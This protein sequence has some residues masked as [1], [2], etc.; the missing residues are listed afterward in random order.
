MSQAIVA[1]Q[2]GL[3]LVTAP[4]KEDAIAISQALIT[5]K[6]AACVSLFPVHSIYTWQGNIEQEDEW[7]LII[8]TDLT[9]FATLAARIHELHPYEV[10]E[11]VALPFQHGAETYLAW[12]GEQ[13]RPAT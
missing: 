1:S 13:V 8:K 5:A 10:P 9:S 11:I 4:S 12:I 3:V 7:Q 6:L 2:F